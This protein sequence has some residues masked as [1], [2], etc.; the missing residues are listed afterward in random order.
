VSLILSSV[1]P[2]YTG[3]EVFWFVIIAILWAGYFVL[4]GFD[5]GIG[6]M[7]GV[8]GR[9]SDLDRRVL[10]NTIGPVWDGNEVWLLTAG[11]ATFAAFP[12]W[13]AT[14]FSGFYLPLFLIL[15]ALIFRGVAFEF[16][17]K[18]ALPAWRV[19]WD[20]AI[21]WGSLL[22]ALLWGVAFANILRG[23]PIGANF[24]YFGSFFNLLNPYSLLGGVTTLLLFS[25]HGAVFASLKTTGELRAR[26]SRTAMLLAPAATAAI[27]AFLAW[28]Y[29]N[30]HNVHNT[31]LVPP[32]V[33]IIAI[34]AVA[35]VGWL[36]REKLEGWAFVAMAV[37]LVCLV[38]TLFLN[39][40]PRVMVSSIS[41][42][43]NLTIGNAASAPYTLKVMT[44]VALIFTPIVLVYQGWSYWVF[45]AR[46]Q[47]PVQGDPDGV[48]PTTGPIGPD[49]VATQGVEASPAAE[50]GV[51]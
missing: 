49:P 30:A 1:A 22:P 16:R 17:A 50:S 51:S 4:E 24:S 2:A 23:V 47:G 9:G 38:A 46:V 8:L 41:P 39:L 42:A 11:G 25:L 40:Y 21:F 31:G 35:V 12:N 26:A 33:P 13:Y 28:T 6:I 7:L 37:G 48:E 27:V 45:R 44:I 10:I 5:F 19:A 15:A 32:F 14:L 34:A 36:L 3:F 43:Y 20:H 18:R 29:V